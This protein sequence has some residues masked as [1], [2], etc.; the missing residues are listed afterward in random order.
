M[1]TLITKADGSAM[2]SKI[3]AIEYL[4]K[5]G[6]AKEALITKNGQFY[7]ETEEKPQVIEE[8]KEVKKQEV[9]KD[10]KPVSDELTW[11][12]P[13]VIGRNEETKEPIFTKLTFKTND[14]D[15]VLRAKH[16]AGQNYARP[17]N[18]VEVKVNGS[19]T[20]IMSLDLASK[21]FKV[22]QPEGV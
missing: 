11:D 2:K 6:I 13:V 17:F 20:F 22:H 3:H 8:V 16:P 9:K 21:L 1:E 10:E 18:A 14:V 12:T 4:K 19:E 5:Q 15:V 7:Y